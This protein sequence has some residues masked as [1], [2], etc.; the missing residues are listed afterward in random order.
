[1]AVVGAGPVGLTTALGLAHYGIPCVVFEEDARLSLDTKA[2]TTLSRTLEI[3]RRYGVADAIL[4]VALRVDEIGEFDRAT[5]RS[6]APVRLHVL[7][8]ETRYPFVVNLPQQDMEP[9][10]ARAV[11]ARGRDV[12]RL[13]HRLKRFEP[14][15]GGVRLHLETAAGP[16]SFDASYLLACDGG[17]SAVREQLGVAV[18][19]K[20][21]PER[22][23]LVDLAADLDVA[24]PRDYPY[25]AYFSDRKSVV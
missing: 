21:L 24:N 25:L 9:V 16:Q 14:I 4:S 8:H 11:E 2:G 12:L 18:E 3:W 5:G 23:A 1:M 17:R 10:L 15:D 20:S 13:G 22:Y 19:G 7:G 6:P